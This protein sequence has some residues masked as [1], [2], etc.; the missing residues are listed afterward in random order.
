[1]NSEAMSVETHKVSANTAPHD[2]VRGAGVT[3]ALAG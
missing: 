3:D 1:M 2:A